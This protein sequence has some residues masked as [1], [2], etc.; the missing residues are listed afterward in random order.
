MVP[1][2]A[3]GSS[4]R[5]MKRRER[6]PAAAGT[7]GNSSSSSKRSSS[8]RSSAGG[9][10]ERGRPATATNSPSPLQRLLLLGTLLSARQMA[11]KGVTAAM[12]SLKMRRMAMMR[13]GSSS[14]RG[15]TVGRRDS[16]TRPMS[17][18]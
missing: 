3:G 9:A 14:R 16:T 15:S 7:C 1:A 2:A 18:A 17:Q 4:G 10:G 6:G 13:A 12:G 5:L 11:H 8:R